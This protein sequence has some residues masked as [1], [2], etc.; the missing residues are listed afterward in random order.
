MKRRETLMEISLVI[1]FKSLRI[2]ELLHLL[3]SRN[4]EDGVKNKTN[5]VKQTYSP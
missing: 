1:L 2:Y 4:C 3:L 5:F